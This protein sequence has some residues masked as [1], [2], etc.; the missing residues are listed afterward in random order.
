M[1]RRSQRPQYKSPDGYDWR[2]PDMPVLR[3]YRMADGSWRTIIDPDYEHR[4]RE[5]MMSA[6]AQG[7]WRRDETYNLRRKPR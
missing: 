7:S 2:D 4:Y 5:H 3:D 1:S 6:A